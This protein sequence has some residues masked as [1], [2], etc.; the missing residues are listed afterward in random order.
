M[1][2][3][4]RNWVLIK[5]KSHKEKDGYAHQSN[6]RFANTNSETKRNVF[7]LI[8]SQQATVNTAQEK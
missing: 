4:S 1:Q 2:R 8:K 6:G 7:S 3:N 5:C